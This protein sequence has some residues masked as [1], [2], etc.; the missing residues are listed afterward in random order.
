MNIHLKIRECVNK[1]G[2]EI[3]VSNM[4]IGML[5][6]ELVFDEV[7]T[8]PYKKILRNVIKEGYAQKLLN[9]GAYTPDVN[10]LA[11]QY[12]NMNF[13]QETP[14]QY[15]FDC[16]AY[17]LGWTDKE[18]SVGGSQGGNS[19][20]LDKI[21]FVK[22]YL[23]DGIDEDEF[24]YIEFRTDLNS[25]EIQKAID[26]EIRPASEMGNASAD[27][28]LHIIYYDGV[29]CPADKERAN[30]YLNSSAEKGCV[31]AQRELGHDIYYDDG[32]EE[33]G[34]QWIKKAAEQGDALAQV[35]LAECYENGHVV[36]E[37]VAEAVKWYRKAAEQGNPI[38]FTALA[39]CYCYGRG[40]NQDYTEAVKWLKKAIEQGDNIGY[41]LLAEYYQDCDEL[42]QDYAEAVK[43]NLKAA[44]KGYGTAKSWLADH[45]FK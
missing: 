32:R 45:G 5:D 3:I 33:E 17:G 8:I 27:M 36:K 21:D 16:L 14:V 35:Y 6:D 37:D 11:S 29:N 44:E 2:A 4:L 31:V 25:T 38:A 10:F 43:W 40:V 26:E 15:V 41:K 42:K 30:E 7:E 34:V 19:Q 20:S 12:A 9:L 23:V 22:K 13:M 28:V 24:E 39:E 18:P 1:K